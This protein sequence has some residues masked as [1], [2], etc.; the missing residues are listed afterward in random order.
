VPAQR[1]ALLCAALV[2]AIYQLRKK[3]MRT[4]KHIQ[5]V[6][7]AFVPCQPVGVS[8]SRVL[9]LAFA[10]QVFDILYTLRAQFGQRLAMA[11]PDQKETKAAPAAA[12]VETKATPSAVGLGGQARDASATAGTASTA[13]AVPVAA[14][15]PEFKY[16]YSDHWHDWISV[17][18]TAAKPGSLMTEAGSF[19]SFASPISPLINKL[20]SPWQRARLPTR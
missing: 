1:R 20:R 12:A 13:S 8:T 5:T 16:Q 18:A 9:V 15:A 6:L 10:A 14:A 4:L 7:A 3:E 19:L 2:R 17:L 11:P